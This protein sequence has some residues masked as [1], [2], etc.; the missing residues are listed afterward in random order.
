M[1]PQAIELGQKQM[2]HT[3]EAPHGGELQVQMWI[4]DLARQGFPFEW[5]PHILPNFSREDDREAAAWGPNRGGQQR[6]ELGPQ[7]PEASLQ[8]LRA[9]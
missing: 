6:A 2:V 8:G 7:A 5:D 4:S 1:E 9:G 3:R